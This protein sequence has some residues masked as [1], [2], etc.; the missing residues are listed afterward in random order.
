MADKDIKKIIVD[1]AN[2]IGTSAAWE[3]LMNHGISLSM[4]QKLT[5]GN[6]DKKLGQLYVAAILKA[7]K[8]SA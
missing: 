1:W 8:K 3:R 2:Q 5:S 7:M 4:A 6:Y